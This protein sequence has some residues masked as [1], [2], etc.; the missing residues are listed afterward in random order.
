MHLLSVFM[1]VITSIQVILEKLE[2][3]F[4]DDKPKV[5]GGG[6]SGPSVTHNK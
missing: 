2:T 1:E 4:M 3:N 6:I 5:P